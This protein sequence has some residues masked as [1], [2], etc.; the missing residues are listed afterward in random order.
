MIIDKK[1]LLLKNDN[2]YLRPLTIGDITDEYI[3]GLND[4]EVN[5][6]LVNVRLQVQ[7][8]ESV[9][10]FI[11]SNIEN[12]ASILF[13]IFIK[14][15]EQP[16]IG[17]LR[18]SEIDFFHYIASIGI[19]LFT[20]RSW[21]RGYAQQ[22]LN[23]VKDYLFNTV[24]LRFLEAGVYAENLSSINVFTKA[25]FYESYIV[26]GK[27]RHIDSFKDVVYLAAINPN[28]DISLLKKGVEGVASGQ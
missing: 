19:C 24:E 3:N 12:P 23:L 25:G 28:F 21:K 20:K 22:A 26:R 14:E 8:R 6:Y 4:P 16:F 9:K 15:I 2:L 11:I 1:S 17:T 27:Y 7:T 13:G 5:K 10:M 18:V